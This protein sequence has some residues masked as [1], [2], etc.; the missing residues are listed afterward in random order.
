MRFLGTCLRG[1]GGLVAPSL[2][3]RLSSRL[4]G[5]DCVAVQCKRLKRMANTKQSVLSKPPSKKEHGMREKTKKLS[6]YMLREKEMDV[7][8]WGL[9]VSITKC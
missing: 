6:I 3:A 2:C 9:V 7:C 8:S 1:A 4:N 5:P